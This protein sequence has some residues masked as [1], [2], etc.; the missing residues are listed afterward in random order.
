MFTPV[1]PPT[2]ESTWAR[3]VVGI[4][5]NFNP[6]LNWLAAKPVISPVIPPPIEIRQ[7]SLEKFFLIKFQEFY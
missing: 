6:L 1:F 4:L 2:D 5:I 7:S 3:R